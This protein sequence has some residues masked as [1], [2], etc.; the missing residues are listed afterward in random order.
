M[1]LLPA[2]CR[3]LLTSEFASSMKLI[4]IPWYTSN[5][6]DTKNINL[7][8]RNNVFTEFW[9]K[10]TLLSHWNKNSIVSLPINS[11]HPYS[12]M[13]GTQADVNVAVSRVISIQIAESTLTLGPHCFSVKA[14]RRYAAF[15]H[16]STKTHYKTRRDRWV[17]LE[18]FIKKRSYEG[19][20]VIFLSVAH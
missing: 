11:I 17:T 15:Y 5:I 1:W 20:C 9:L 16:P 7:T 3:M 14:N 12:W 18:R 6:T 8:E 2:K 4:E 13:V 10:T 19:A